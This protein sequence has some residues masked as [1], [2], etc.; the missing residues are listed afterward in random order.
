ML[1]NLIK[2][3]ISL[4]SLTVF[5]SE[6]LEIEIVEIEIEIEIVYL[7]FYSHHTKLTGL[8]F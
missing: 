2:T 3:S 1:Y 4:V 8:D 7:F 5:H 6:I